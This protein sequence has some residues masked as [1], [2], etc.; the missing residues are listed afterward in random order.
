[1]L[2]NNE[3]LPKLS[4]PI[5]S[6]NI[7]NLLDKLLCLH[8]IEYLAVDR[9][10]KIQETSLNV[11]EFAEI[12][13]EMEKGKDV[14]DS[15]PELIGIEE[16]LDDILEQRQPSFQLKSVTRILNDGSYF[17]LDLYIFA[18]KD[19]LNPERLIILCEDVTDTAALQ[20]TMVQA[21]NENSIK[22]DYLA[23]ARD[24]FDKVFNSINDILLVTTEAGKIKK[25]NH[26]N[27][28]LDIRNQ[29]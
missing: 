23:K 9:E 16:L 10:L 18:Q 6:Q 11:Q 22:I 13:D 24:Y 19:Q 20:Q 5:S 7:N 28:Y 21:A 4:L 17:Y 14:R 25:F 8:R 12:P 15:F 29:N 3:M 26:S 2:Y 27:Y 1:M